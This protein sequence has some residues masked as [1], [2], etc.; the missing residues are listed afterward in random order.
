MIAH[1]FGL[2]GELQVSDKFPARTIAKTSGEAKKANYKK[3]NKE[4][5][6]LKTQKADLKGRLGR[7]K[8]TKKK[9]IRRAVCR[10]RMSKSG[11]NIY[12]YVLRL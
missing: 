11:R 3:L 7:K 6:K 8:N 10:L 1:L 12:N 4:M 5:G 2:R 9:R